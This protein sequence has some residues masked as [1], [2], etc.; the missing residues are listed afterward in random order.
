VA[1]FASSVVTPERI[2][3]E[4]EVEAVMLRTVDGEITFLAGHS[5][6]IGVVQPGLLR[7]QSEDGSVQRV[8]VHG[9]FVEVDERG[10]TVLAPIAELAEEIDVE[11]AR[12]SLQ[13]AEQRLAE[14]HSTGRGS[15]EEGERVDREVAA[16]EDDKRRA[17]VR[18]E[19]AEG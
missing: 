19:V 12:Q 2:L 11:R 15:A 4:R 13:V 8:A 10:V 18:V 9:G 7:L 6:L 3:V 16:A 1:T 17:E 14:L 5:P